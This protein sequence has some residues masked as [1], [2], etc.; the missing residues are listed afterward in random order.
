MICCMVSAAAI[1]AILWVKG[2]VRAWPRALPFVLVVVAGITVIELGSHF[3]SRAT[4]HSHMGSPLTAQDRKTACNAP[5]RHADHR[6]V[7]MLC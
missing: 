4:A 3:G 6:E 5:G 2:A 1:G 7:L